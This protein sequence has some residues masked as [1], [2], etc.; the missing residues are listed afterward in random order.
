MKTL[1][2]IPC[3][4]MIQGEFVECLQKMHI[5]GEAEVRYLRGSLVYDARNQLMQYALK[6]GGYDFMLWLDSDMTFE[7][8]LMERM[9]ASIGDKPMLTGLCF[10]RRPPFKPCIY[11]KMELKQDG[12]GWEPITENYF[13]YP[14]DSIFE[15]EACGFAC[16]IQRM[17]MLEAMSVFGVPFFPVAGM[18]EDL[19]FCYRAKKLDFK[20]WCDSGIKLGHLMKISMD[21]ATRDMMIS[22]GMIRDDIKPNTN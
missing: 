12:I 1:I 8:D 11:N 10:G 17:D 3:T 21:E 4:D 5:V 13:D 15:V 19:S 22:D 2:G 18:G 9:I 6:K 20:I 7:P 16:V 14:R